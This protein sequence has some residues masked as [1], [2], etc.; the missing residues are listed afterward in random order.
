MRQCN[1]VQ[2][3]VSEASLGNPGI[4]PSSLMSFLRVKPAISGE[5]FSKC[6][7]FDKRTHPV[8]AW[9]IMDRQISEV[10]DVQ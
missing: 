9:G 6:S 10:T 1:W 2:A 5:D 4:P 3:E 8:S 7:L